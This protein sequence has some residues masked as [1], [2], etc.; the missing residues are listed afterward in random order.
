MVFAVTP[1][2]DFLTPPR[3]FALN[4]KIPHGKNYAVG[5]VTE[6]C[7]ILFKLQF[8]FRLSHIGVL[9]FMSNISDVTA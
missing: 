8:E 7:L 9:L 1:P 5:A 6:G 4:G 2:W 3:N